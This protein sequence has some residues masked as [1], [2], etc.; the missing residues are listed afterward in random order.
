MSIFCRKI[1]STTS[2]SVNIKKN[3][4]SVFPSFFWGGRF[5]KYSTLKAKLRLKDGAQPVFKKKRNILFATLEEINKELDRLEQVGILSKTEFSKWAASTVHVKKK[6]KQI[7]ICADFSTGLN[8]ALQDNHYP[9]PS[10]EEIFNK[11][12][13]KN[14]QYLG[15]PLNELLKKTN[16]E[17]QESF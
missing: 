11:L 8:D 13:F 6:S 14:M 7:R 12:N 5:G 17:C 15:W 10:P 4:N 1:E 2:N 3:S 16:H 9:L